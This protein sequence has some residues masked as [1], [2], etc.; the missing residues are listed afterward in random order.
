MNKKFKIFLLKC[1]LNE[2]FF[3]ENLSVILDFLELPKSN[4][5]S[6]TSEITREEFFKRK[7]KKSINQKKEKKGKKIDFKTIKKNLVNLLKF[8]KTEQ[9]K[10]FFS[11]FV[12]N[13]VLEIEII[14]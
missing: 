6:I 4:F 11:Q 5:K 8:G 2:Q 10:N 12:K 3:Y 13:E 14:L 1:I 9:T 7:E